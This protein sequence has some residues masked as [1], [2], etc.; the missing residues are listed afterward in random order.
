MELLVDKHA[1]YLQFLMI[2][3]E[4]TYTL[5]LLLYCLISA[6][7]FKFGFALESSSKQNQQ[8]DYKWQFHVYPGWYQYPKLS[9]NLFNDIWLYL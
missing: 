5:I 3:V 4:Q 6:F 2:N 9:M 1:F 8:L 7:I